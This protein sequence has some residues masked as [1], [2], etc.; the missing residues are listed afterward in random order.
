MEEHGLRTSYLPSLAGLHSQIYKFKRLLTSLSPSLVDHF[1]D[2]GMEFAYLSPWFLTIFATSCPLPLLFR[3]YDVILAEGAEETIMR[4]ALALMLRNEAKLLEMTELENVVQLLLGKSIWTFYE[5]DPDTLFEEVGTVYHSVATK[6]ALEKLQEGFTAE[7]QGDESTFAARSLGFSQSMGFRPF[8]FLDGLWAPSPRAA[9]LS[10]EAPSFFE[11]SA[12]FLKRSNSKRSIATINSISAV[13]GTETMHS[14]DSYA[15]TAS[16]APTEVEGG[17]E[18]TKSIRSVRSAKSVKTVQQ[19]DKNWHEQ[20]EGLLMAMTE[21][22]RQHAETASELEFAQRN[23]DELK[24]LVESLS[25]ILRQKTAVD[26]VVKQ[27]RKTLPSRVLD[28]PTGR[29]HLANDKLADI[30]HI[31]DAV[32]DKADAPLESSL[33]QL[34]LVFEAEKALTNDFSRRSRSV[35]DAGKTTATIRALESEVA[36]MRRRVLRQRSKAHLDNVQKLRR[37]IVGLRLNVD[38]CSPTQLPPR[39]RSDIGPWREQLHYGKTRRKSSSARSPRSTSPAPSVLDQASE[40]HL[41]PP[42]LADWVPETTL[43]QSLS[44]PEPPTIVVQPSQPKHQRTFSKRTS[45]LAAQPILSTQNHQ[46]PAEET[47]LVELVEAKTREA[48]AIQERD[49]MKQQ[50]DRMR[51]AMAAQQEAHQAELERLRK[52]SPGGSLPP[53]PGEERLSPSPAL[54]PDLAPPKGSAGGGGWF[55]GVRRTASTS[56]ASGM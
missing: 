25:V 15:S 3:I 26:A 50:L 24:K 40:T 13:S 51:K 7:T 44:R 34:S 9:T 38:A 11:G 41:A 45:S 43:E 35:G 48:L 20:V 32:K 1:D 36:K 21:V 55:W 49:E 37:D 39:R 8:K 31:I 33:A 10:P 47:L 29:P 18:R 23:N 14:T 12:G 4:V 30:Q 17:L 52:G 6:E 42:T 16:T 2:L 53:T 27:R 5:S 28:K 22:Q 46:P 56:A 54:T 19:E